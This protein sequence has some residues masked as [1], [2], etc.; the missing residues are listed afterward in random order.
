GG[1]LHFLTGRALRIEAVYQ[2]LL[3]LTFLLPGA[4]TYALLRRVLGSSWL[5]LPGA[6][7]ALTLSA[8]SRSG[9]EEG[10]RWGLVASRLGWALLPLL[11]LTVPA[12]A[13][14]A[15]L[16]PGAGAIL[17]AVNLTPPRPPPARFPAGFALVVLAAMRGPGRRGERIG[18]AAFTA[19]AA[20][21]LSAFWLA[22]LLA[23]LEMALPLAWGDASLASLARQLATRP[24]LV[25]LAL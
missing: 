22:P 5:A 25:A 20:L 15:R 19:I 13:D 8:G 3:W 9:V 7:L 12:A 11:A 10:L 21:G 16:S 18:R 6:F 24:L 17:A 2:T 1:A 14:H 4:T 23:H